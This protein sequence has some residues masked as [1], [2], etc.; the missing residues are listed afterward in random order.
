MVLKEGN[1]TGLL[2]AA[3]A[4]QDVD[5][6]WTPSRTGSHT[7]TATVSNGNTT[8]SN[9]TTVNVASQS[10]PQN[11]WEQNITANGVGNKQ[12]VGQV[13]V[14]GRTGPIAGAVVTIHVYAWSLFQGI[15][16]QNI[17][18]TTDS[19][20]ADSLVVTVPFAA[21]YALWVTN[22]VHGPDTYVPSQ[23]KVWGAYTYAS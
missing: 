18:A 20:G 17:Q 7:L 12:I 15:A 10:N 9:S 16:S 22:I 13:S 5:I 6:P 14:A 19:N 1:Q 8:H 4:G 3:S 11:I 2:L 23:N 21:S